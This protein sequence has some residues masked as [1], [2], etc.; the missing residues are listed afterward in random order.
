VQVGAFPDASSADRVVDRLRRL[1]FDSYRSERV[2]NGGSRHRV[3]VRPGSG[4]DAR[5]L[6]GT[7]RKRGFDVWITR[8]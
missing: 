1:G 6:A 2:G 3:R 8:E 4:L 7:L 5:A